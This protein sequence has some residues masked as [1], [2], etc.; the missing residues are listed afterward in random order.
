MTIPIGHVDIVTNSEDRISEKA[1]AI[2]LVW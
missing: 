2:I 1:K